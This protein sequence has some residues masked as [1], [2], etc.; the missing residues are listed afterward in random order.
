M[1][2]AH[3]HTGPRTT[4]HRPRI[5]SIL[6]DLGNV[7]VKFDP[8]I[9]EEGYSRHGKIKKGALVDYIMDS[10][11]GNKYMEGKLT[12]SKF[13]MMTCRKFRLDIKFNDFYNIWNSIF[14]PY[15]EMEK[16]V[17]ALKQKYTD[18]K[19]ILLSNTNE[20]HY[21]FLRRE[22]PVLDLFDLHVVS[23]EVGAQ[24]P[25]AK[26]FK[27]ALSS[28]E[29]LPKETFYT[30]DRDDLIEAARILGIRA[31]QFTDHESLKKQLTKFEINI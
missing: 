2:R 29:T 14:F 3:T 11:N 7:V 25:K 17:R 19:L 4:D 31:F 28:A 15:P 5:K 27:E 22:Y 21:D 6:F 8:A 24:K 20:Q 18:I 23:H 1:S 26:M 30:D 13:Y 10:D 12:S 9:A 16:M